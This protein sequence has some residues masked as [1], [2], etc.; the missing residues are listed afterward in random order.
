MNNLLL[1]KNSTIESW[2]INEIN[3][4]ILIVKPAIGVEVKGVALV[5]HPLP[6]A[7]GTN[8]NKVVQTLVKVVTTL[9][10][11]AYCPNF[12]GVGSS[13]GVFDNGIAELQDSIQIYHK[14]R[15]DKPNLPIILAGF[16]F[17][18]AMSCKL[19]ME[20]LDYQA[21][22]LVSPSVIKHECR[23]IDQDK[24]IIVY[25]Q[26]DEVIPMSQVYEWATREEVV[27]SI[28]PAAGHYYHGRLLQLQKY[29]HKQLVGVL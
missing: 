28:F 10:Y 29:L 19:S 3:I 25:G 24:T 21:L 5:L 18:G 23:I 16:S 15:E 2:Q 12:R 7:G 17:G 4:E 11:I 26:E 9:G 27:L 1:P 6:I 13:T 14:I 22:I 20:M 8:T